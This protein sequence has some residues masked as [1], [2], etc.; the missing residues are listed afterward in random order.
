MQSSFR[1]QSAGS[2]DVRPALAVAW[3]RPA[4]AGRPERVGHPGY[5]RGSAP[6]KAPVR[7]RAPAS[8]DGLVGAGGLNSR[9][10]VFPAPPLDPPSFPQRVVQSS[11]RLQSAG[12]GD[13]RPAP[14]RPHQRW[15]TA[16]PSRGA[17]VPLHARWGDDGDGWAAR[18]RMPLGL[19]RL[20]A[21]NE[22]SSDADAFCPKGIIRCGPDRP[23]IDLP[24]SRPQRTRRRTRSARRPGCDAAGAGDVR[25]AARRLHG[26]RRPP[27]LARRLSAARR[28]GEDGDGWVRGGECLWGC[29]GSQLQRA[30]PATLAPS[31]PKAFSGAGP[32]ANHAV[33]PL[34]R[35]LRTRRR[36]RPTCR[37]GPRRQ[38]ERT[39]RQPPPERARDDCPLHADGGTTVMG[40]CAAENAFGAVQAP[41]SN[42]P[43]QRRV[44]P[45]A[46]KAFSGA[47]PTAHP[48]D[49]P[50]LDRCGP[51]AAEIG[52]PARL[53]RLTRCR[54]AARRQPPARRE[55]AVRCT[56]MWGGR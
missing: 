53:R 56:P 24:P 47:G 22:P 34:S 25:P 14:R 28:C 38:A 8:L 44:T 2:G 21:A 35:P 46:P 51:G 4:L 3:L 54:P 1:L 33:L 40:G 52:T 45:S 39:C 37:P 11:F 49:L 19:F 50:P 27:R 26:A 43:V 55:A 17:S 42:E 18:R 9:T 23:P 10:G 29:S 16:A 12:A 36:T 48:I 20:P 32:T 15:P 7:Q 13:V 5:A 6:E 30:R 31:A 41:G